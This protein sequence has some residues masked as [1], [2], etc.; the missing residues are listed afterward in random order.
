MED[1]DAVASEAFESPLVVKSG[2]DEV[3]KNVSNPFA[4]SSSSPFTN[5]FS[6]E[7]IGGSIEASVTIVNSKQENTTKTIQKSDS[8]MDSFDPF[9]TR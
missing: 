4:G 7:H 2:S 1:V 9:S 5:G 3:D 6:A 8:F